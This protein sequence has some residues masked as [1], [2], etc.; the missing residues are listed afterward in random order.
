MTDR[1]T[2]LAER[3]TGIGGSDVAPIMGLSKWATPLSVYLDKIGE[4]Q[5]VEETPAM[6]WGTALEPVILSAYRDQTG[7]ATI[8]VPVLLRHDKHPFVIGTPDGIAVDRI[9]EAKTAR[10]AEGWGE[11]GSDE[12][13]EPYILQ[14]QHYMMLTGKALADVAVLIGGSDFRVYTIPADPELQGMMLDAEASFWSR[15]QDRIPPEP[16]TYADAV[17]RFGRAS[18]AASVVATE[19]IQQDYRCLVNTRAQIAKLEIWADEL[20]G[21]LTCR[22]G[23]NDTLVDERGNVLATWKAAK[24]PARFNSAAFAADYPDL[25]KQYTQPG[26]PSRRF[27]IKE[28]NQ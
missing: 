14:V 21:N 19:E 17:A 16:V 2:W 8:P 28:T 11:P 1:E 6:R 4:G 5:P 9:V 3:R 24:A 10:S 20:K 13:P 25:F 23:E 7:F 15:V 12:I 22:M 27:L 18:K 26:T